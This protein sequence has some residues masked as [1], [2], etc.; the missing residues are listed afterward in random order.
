MV[1]VFLLAMLWLPAPTAQAQVS[2]PAALYPLLSSP[3]LYISDRDAQQLLEKR[4]LAPRCRDLAADLAQLFFWGGSKEEPDLKRAWHFASLSQRDKHLPSQLRVLAGA[5]SLAG[6]NR[7]MSASEALRRF[8]RELRADDLLRR[9]KAYAVLNQLQL[10][11]PRVSLEGLPLYQSADRNEFAPQAAEGLVLN[12]DLGL[13]LVAND[14]GVPTMRWVGGQPSSLASRHSDGRLSN[15]PHRDTGS[16]YPE[17][18]FPVGESR[19]AQRWQRWDRHSSAGVLYS[20]FGFANGDYKE[21]RCTA[22]AIA[23]RWLVTAA[24]CLFASDR[25]VQH[26]GQ[27]RLEA[28]RFNAH[29]AGKATPI[30]VEAAW[31]HRRHR[32]QDLAANRLSAYSGSDIAVLRLSQALHSVPLTSLNS[33]AGQ[34]DILVRSS[35]FP[36]DRSSAGTWINHCR[37]GLVK[38]GEGELM[39]LYAM[40]CPFSVGQSGSLMTTRSGPSGPAAG[41]AVGLL[42][43]NL[44][45]SS[46]KS[47]IFAA[48][49]AELIRDIDSLLSPDGRPQYLVEYPIA[50]PSL[51]TATDGGN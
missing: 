12:A 11:L 49:S 39:D 30:G 8:E 10:F 1:T 46:H 3:S 42:S 22:T 35:G 41:A 25:D 14:L 26:N 33:L 44:S 24:H 50:G 19:Q 16:Q 34:A 21:S 51:A 7:N 43:A 27:A 29:S 2:C 6:L 15:A 13:V 18:F 47:A 37:A 38:R 5:F 23:S 40:N 20:G 4:H 28:M 31:I 17:L 32:P 45:T 9:D 36:K 48:F